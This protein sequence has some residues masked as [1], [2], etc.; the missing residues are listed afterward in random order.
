MIQRYNNPLVTMNTSHD[1]EYVLYADAEQ[2]LERLREALRQIIA[3][4][5]GECQVA[6]DDTGG[7]AWIDTHARAAMSNKFLI[8]EFETN[9]KK[10]DEVCK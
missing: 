1:G 9:T 2:E 5:S 3:V 4:A 8:C 7:M 6:E 10:A